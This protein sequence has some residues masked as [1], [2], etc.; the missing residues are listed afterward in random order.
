MTA[1]LITMK[2]YRDLDLDATPCMILPCGHIFTVETL[3]QQMGMAEH[4]EMQDVAGTSQPIAVRG[5]PRPLCSEK[6][7]AC[8][9]CRSSLR[10]VSRYG[11]I[12]RRSLLDESTKKFITWANRLYLPLAER[13]RK[14]EEALKDSAH[15]A[16]VKGNIKLDGS[17][18]MALLLPAAAGDRYAN[19][20]GLRRRIL[21]FLGKV[22]VEEQPFQKVCDIVEA[23]RRRHG[24]EI[25]AFD[26]DQ[27]ILQTRGELLAQAL[28]LRCEL[29]MF[30]DLLTIYEEMDYE[31]RKDFTVV[32]NLRS[33][34]K[35]CDDLLEKAEKSMHVLQ[36]AEANIFWAYFA[37][38][39]YGYSLSSDTIAHLE[40]EGNA[41]LN[42]A[43]QL[44]DEYPKQT[45]SVSAGI[46][47]VRKMFTDS[48][49][50]AEMGMVVVTMEEFSGTGHWYRCING[51]PFT[52]GECGGPNQTSQC[53]PR[54]GKPI[55]GE[56]HH[57]AEGVTVA[58]DIEQEFGNLQI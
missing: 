27:T 36:Q 54:C 49:S 8:P 5:D 45:A 44:C 51:H 56:D 10:N 47:A 18:M 26:F 4:Y 23:V 24:A 29:I 38:L 55:G 40:Q 17:P 30:K 21:S 31:E 11:R 15:K 53:L 32:I 25:P 34:R 13:L 19:L 41:R 9:N 7:K 28:L 57:A 52:I 20:I 46:A 39:E 22:Q 1:D 2:T 33:G 42:S 14:L 6:P 48:I 43:Q 37:A 35:A 50:K 3:D 16:Q 12:V 58:H